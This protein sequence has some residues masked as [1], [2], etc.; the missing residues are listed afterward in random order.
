[1]SNGEWHL[2]GDC[3]EL[4]FVNN[5]LNDKTIIVPNL[6]EY[7]QKASNLCDFAGQLSTISYAY[8]VP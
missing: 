5:L 3:E 1:M 4:C 7:P 2:H 8:I 6:A